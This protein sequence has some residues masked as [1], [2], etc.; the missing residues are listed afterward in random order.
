M[1]NSYRIEQK[2]EI[3]HALSAKQ[4]ESVEIL[5]MNTEELETYIQEEQ[6]SNPMIEISEKESCVTFPQNIV[7]AVH[8]SE[9]GDYSKEFA[10]IPDRKQESLKQYLLEQINPDQMSPACVTGCIQLIQR[11]S[12]DTGYFE[13]DRETLMDE[14]GL[15]DE[16]MEEVLGKIRSMDPPGIGAFDLRE[17]LL[18]QL[19]RNGELTKN[20]ET[21]IRDH[22][23]DVAAGRISNISRHLHIKTSQ[24][25]D[26][27]LKIHMLNPR[28]ANGFGPT[29]ITYIVPDI[30]TNY[31]NG[32]WEVELNGSR[33]NLFHLNQT[34]IKM[35]KEAKDPD[36]IEYFAEKIKRARELITA[37]EH[38]ENTLV[39][40][41]LYLLEKQEKFAL[42][43][44]PKVRLSQKETA[45]ILGVHPSTINRA[46]KNKYVQLPRGVVPLKEFF[47]NRNEAESLNNISRK[48]KD[49]EMTTKT[50][51][52]ISAEMEKTQKSNKEQ[53]MMD[54]K[55]TPI[56]LI[57]P[58]KEL[59]LQSRNI[60]HIYERNIDVFQ[61]SLNDAGMLARSLM[62]QGA[63]IFISRRG[64][65]KSI[66]EYTKAP[67]VQIHTG[68]S[69]YMPLMERAVLV[70]GK[71]AFFSYGVI[72][73]DV[74]TMCIMLNIEARYYSFK[75]KTEAS[76][77]VRE[78]VKDGCILGIGGADQVEPAKELGLPYLVVE[79]T[80]TSLIQAI[81]A[82]EQ[83]LHVKR[84][85]SAKQQELK[86]RLE[87]YETSIQNTHDAILGIDLEGKVL[88][89]NQEALRTLRKD[90]EQLIGVNA[91]TLF[92]DLD[93]QA[94]IQTGQKKIDELIH[95]NGNLM[96]ADVV[97]FIVDEK[98]AGGVITLQYV[99]NI[100]KKEK[101][102]R[103][104]LH[105]K[106][107]FAK[108]HFTDIIGTSL[109]IRKAL[110]LAKKFAD[111]ESTILLQ[112]ETGTGKEMFAQ[113]IHNASKRSSG[114]FVAVNCSSL[115]RD[116]LEAE[117]FGYVEGA[118]TGAVKGGKIGLFEL[119]HGGTIFLDEIG[120]M[121]LD[122]QAKFLRVLQE[123]EIMRLGS[124]EVTPIDI[125]IIAATNRNLKQDIANHIFRADLYYRINVLNIE[126]PP[127][128][129]R[130]SDIEDLGLHIF[131]QL[132]PV[133]D[134]SRNAVKEILQML[135][136]YSWP[137]NVR[138]LRNVIERVSVLLCK[139]DSPE[140]VK[141]YV[142]ESYLEDVSTLQCKTEISQ[143]IPDTTQ[144]VSRQEI[145]KERILKSL[146][147]NHHEIVNTAKALGIS[148]STLWRKMKAYGIE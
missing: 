75:N 112:G 72:S 45:E 25:H 115:P 67:T 109:A 132:S 14:L 44:G 9:S 62:Q 19:E 140:D 119:A 39:Q 50:L 21:V 29:D 97:P 145:E 114:P 11:I 66:E 37:I 88:T 1:E 120:E 118:F 74:R 63:E 107:L 86:T 13:S 148:R 138:E 99:Q 123:K 90:A 41:I 81:D 94:V 49:L 124:D 122:T 128:R 73:E 40:M 142:A 147:E 103:L 4:I 69:D 134:E 34:Y 15:N 58:S 93:V 84:R 26:I 104:K 95:I 28:P 64:T 146:A 141:R 31:V 32:K 85:E 133:S 54:K 105:S 80:A 27:I 125:R 126:I 57:A 113:S 38:R 20:I 87:R 18:L 60:I 92:R 111:V 23:D 79:S 48:D 6:L 35:A 53:K 51:G 108:Y 83:L 129:D 30:L 65:L 17:C 5:S 136:N 24:V 76:D 12:E 71:V 127:L 102:I 61:A 135:Q 144:R 100:Q 78:A 46:V 89:A 55:V 91:R 106:G 7:P 77:V 68:L 121:P 10:E 139:G 101:N 33:R 96:T 137:G 110:N 42:G 59:A 131:E 82:A 47:L 8:P 98:I 70:K 16:D 22:L 52:E 3:K 117:L 36:I 43:I 116:I 143:R 2:L 56:C 130:G